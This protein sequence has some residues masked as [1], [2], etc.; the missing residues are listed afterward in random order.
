MASPF[1]TAEHERLASAPA[2][3]PGD[4]KAIGPYVSER[5]WGTVRE[6]YSADG[7]GLGVLPARPRPLARLPLE[8]GRPGRRLRRRPAPVPRAR[9]LERARPDP[10]GADLRPDRRRG[11][12]RRGRQGV[13]VVPRRDADRTR[14]CAGATTTR[15]PS[16]R[17]R[18]CARRTRGA[19][20]D[21]PRVRAAR[22]R[23]LR[24][25]PLLGRSTVDYAKAAPR[26]HLHA[27]P[28]RA[29]PGPRP[30]TLHVLPTLWFRNRWSWERR[31]RA[32]RDPRCRTRRRRARIA[33]E[34]RL[35]RWR[36]VAGPIRPARRRRCS[37]ART[38]RNAA[39]LFGRA[40][41]DAVPEGRHQRPRRRRRA[42]P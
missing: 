8:R 7:D 32:A 29:T 37:S 15:R 25:R 28:R 13:L 18:G 5:A 14:G 2:G 24:R 27:H 22:H 31:R 12:P 11:Q 3:R 36:L 17:T 39:R 41:A 34:E 1:R 42:R 16:S 40:G 26:R 10:Q 9:V 21:E 38:R 19:A 30:P 4:W 20:G 6:D 23:R 35:G 33:E